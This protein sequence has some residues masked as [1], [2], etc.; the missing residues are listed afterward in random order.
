MLNASFHFHP[1]LN[2]ITK[3][4]TKAELH[5]TSSI[6]L[7][8]AG[9]TSSVMASLCRGDFY[10]PISYLSSTNAATIHFTSDSSGTKVGFV[11]AVTVGEWISLHTYIDLFHF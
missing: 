11:A 5:L 1:S 6:L 7:T 3:N 9:I 2:D 4:N 8:G 10:G